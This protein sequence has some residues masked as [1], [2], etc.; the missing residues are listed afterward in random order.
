VRINLTNNHFWNQNVSSPLALI[1]LMVLAFAVA[2][3]TVTTGQKVIDNA[4]NSSAFN[5]Q[6]RM[7]KEMPGINSSVGKNNPS[8]AQT[9]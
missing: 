6:K 2:W 9:Q 7:Q 3:F 5:I 4:K 1:F 8:A